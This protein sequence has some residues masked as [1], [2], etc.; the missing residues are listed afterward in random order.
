[1]SDTLKY[2]FIVTF[3]RTGSTALQLALNAI[4]GLVIR[5]ENHNVLIK[6]LAAV[7]AAER[8]RRE[9]KTPLSAEKPWFGAAEM[10]VEGFGAGMVDIVTRHVLRP[11]SDT[12]VIGFK[13]I[14]YTAPAM[15]RK[16]LMRVTGRMLS[17]FPGARIIFLTRNPEQVARSSW[18]KDQETEDVIR[19]LNRTIANFEVAHDE[20]GDRSFLL[21]HADY[22]E[23]PAGLLPLLSWLGED[24]H[25]D[26]VMAALGTKLSHGKKPASR[27]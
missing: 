19:K 22:A 5:G 10:D 20:Y 27:Q 12:R 17:L 13:E 11:E 24:A 25:A 8:S 9:H 16:E 18:W 21:D 3:G 15:P 14:R 23:D 26:A 1:M 4:P 2:L 6:A 7:E